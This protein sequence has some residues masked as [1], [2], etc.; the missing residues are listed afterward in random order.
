MMIMPVYLLNSIMQFSRD[1]GFFDMLCCDWERPGAER[2]GAKRMLIGHTSAKISVLD[3]STSCIATTVCVS[4]FYNCF[5][6]Q[7]VSHHITSLVYK[8]D[9]FLK[10][11]NVIFFFTIILQFPAGQGIAVLRSNGRLVACGGMSGDIVLKD[12]RTM[13]AEHT[14]DAHPGKISSLDLKG[15]LLVSCGLAPRRG[16]VYCDS[17][18]K[19]FDIRQ[20]VRPLTNIP[21]APGATTLRFQP[22]FSSIVLATSASG[23]FLLTDVQGGGIDFQG[24]QVTNVF[25]FSF[26][27]FLDLFLIPSQIGK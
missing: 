4:S 24:Y 14:I 11:K 8:I 19:V 16:R 10:L 21:F 17:V 1:K 12:L 3:L 18:I 26:M 25:T 7:T 6:F 15:D 13:K 9:S 20:Q 5:L 22:K 27:S 2:P 23:A